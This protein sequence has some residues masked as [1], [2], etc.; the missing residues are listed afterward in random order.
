MVEF[1]NEC[2]SHWG[3][4]HETIA[5]ETGKVRSSPIYGVFVFKKK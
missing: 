2:I 5:L 4:I 3:F 1:E